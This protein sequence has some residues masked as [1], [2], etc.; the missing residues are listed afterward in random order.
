M[1]LSGQDSGRGTFSQR[2]GVLVDT[3]D[4]ER[5][6]ARS[7]IWPRTR[8][9]FE[10]YNSPLSEAGVLGFEYG[11]SPRAAPTP[12][13]SGRPSSGISPTTPR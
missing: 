2:H 6:R 4:R 10:V 8:P 9:P 1:R 3:R 11:Y 13:C 12:W 5:L 7:P